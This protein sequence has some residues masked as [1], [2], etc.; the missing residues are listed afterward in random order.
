M[1][2]TSTIRAP[3]G[4]DWPIPPE[5]APEDLLDELESVLAHRHRLEARAAEL[6]QRAGACGAHSHDGYSSMTAMLK[7]RMS[8]YAG[9]A[10]QLVHRG[11]GL[12]EAPLVALAYARGALSGAKVDVLLEARAV[13]SEAFAADEGALVET[14]MD[15]PLVADLKKHLDYWLAELAPEDLEVDRGLIREA[16]SLNLRR[17]GE[18]VRISGWLDLEAGER[19]RAELEAG[20]PAV[21][22]SRSAAARRADALVDILNGASDRPEL[23]VH[24]DFDRLAG[25]ASGISETT[26]GTFLTDEALR[27]LC[28]DSRLTRV[29]FGPGSRPLDVGRTKRL[30]PPGMRTAVVARDRRCVFPGCDR[31]PSWCD[32]HHL[33][34]WMEGGETEVDNLCLLCRHHHTLVHETGWTVRGMPGSLRFFRPD[35]TELTSNPSPPWP[36]PWIEFDSRP[37]TFVPGELHEIIRSLPRWRDP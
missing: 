15:I 23:I 28:C 31:Q 18:M 2:D 13:A 29:V 25:E 36:S 16:R 4:R 11:N 30:V 27:R 33:K 14:A 7:H 9:E 34:A 1:F 19:L 22:D 3:G 10:H 37:R 35:G 32:V 6:V 5:T 21:G 26:T 24:V 8:L 20:P 12:A 17:D